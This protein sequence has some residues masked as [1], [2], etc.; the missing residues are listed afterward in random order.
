MTIEELIAQAE[1][2]LTAQFARIDRMEEIGTRRVLDAFREHQVAYRH[3]AP[4]TGYGYD[5]V[6]RDTLEKIFAE[7]FGTQAA[8]VRP[9]I[10]S[11]THAISLCLFG[12]VLPGDDIVSATG[13]PYDTLQDIIGWGEGDAPVASLRE[14][15]VSFHPVALR[16]GK[17]DLDAVENAITPKT[18]LVIAQRSRDDS[19]TPMQWDTSENAGF[20][21]GTPWIGIADNYKAINAAAQMDAPDSIRSFYKTLVALRKKMPVISAGKIEFLYPDNA[22]LL[23]Y[24]RY[25]SE[26]ELLV[27]CNLREREI[28]KPLPVGWTDAEKLLGNYP[29]TADTLRPYECVVL[30]K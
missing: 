9:Q 6:G 26:T 2:G 25:D 3:F 27:L 16:G 12:L 30:K 18:K 14:M 28:A 22:D 8:I 21:T 1:S 10:A 11:G 19:R 17:I 7:L 23:A 13:M 15:G 4:T 29:D 5:D 24:R 20:T